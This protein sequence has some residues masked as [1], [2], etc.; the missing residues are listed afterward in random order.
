MFPV[1][2]GMK[3]LGLVSMATGRKSSFLLLA[4]MKQAIMLGAALWRGPRGKQWRATSGQPTGSKAL[5]ATIQR[6]T[7]S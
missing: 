6:G 7:V 1:P 3:G 4:L 5:R 2:E